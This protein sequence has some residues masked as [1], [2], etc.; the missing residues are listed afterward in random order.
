[1]GM[2]ARVNPFFE[3]GLV[4]PEP[5]AAVRAYHRSLPEYAPTPLHACSSL[6]GSLG[7]GEL[8]V[9][10]ESWRFGLNAFKALSASWALHRICAARGGVTTVAAATQGNHGRPVAWAARRLGLQ[11]V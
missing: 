3:P 9:K 8:L 4:P 10:D 7:V 1:M 2:A 11:A 6:A 5:P